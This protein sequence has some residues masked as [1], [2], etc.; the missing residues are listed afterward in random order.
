MDIAINV[1]NG[2]SGEWRVEDFE[3]TEAGAKFE[4][5][6]AAFHPGGRYV[7]AGVYKRLMRGGVVVMS[8][9]PSEISDHMYFINT[10]KKGGDILINGLGLG[11][12]LK[13]ILTS[14]EIKSVTVI[15]KSEDVINLV[16]PA[17]QD[18][19]VTIIN[20]D[21]FDW[22]PPKGKRYD[23][24]WHDIW[25]YICADNLPEMTRLHR[26]Y[27]RRANWQGSWCKELCLRFK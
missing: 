20:T 21:A 16:A 15:E 1:S 8:N 11:V 14:K 13:E 5:M 25:D 3:I 26:K 24:V 4:N 23:A 7:K 17:Y 27:G 22:I 9:T 2:V 18:S 10:A 19:R 6:R 12:A